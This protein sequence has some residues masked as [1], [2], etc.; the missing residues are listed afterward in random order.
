MPVFVFIAADLVAIAIMVFG[1]YFPR[2]RKREM[3]AP[4]LAINVGV[5]GV[6]YAMAT[7]DLSLGFGLG[8]FAVLSIIR[9]RSSEMDHAE[10]AYYFTAIALGLLGGFPSISESVSFTLMA[11]L[12]LVLAAGD[13]P[14]LFAR[15][16]QHMLVLDRAVPNEL[17]AKDLAEAMLGATVKRITIRKVD[18]VL[19]T[20]L[21]D[22]RYEVP[23]V[24][25][26]V[27]SPTESIP[28][29]AGTTSSFTNI[30]VTR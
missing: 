21:C 10:I 26:H 2:H 15:S 3:I 27:A 24:D 22:V 14:R 17:A 9:L 5:M 11:V 23:I 8:I 12:L 28:T 29:V 4:F 1:M 6:T 16:R 20:T 19:D 25:P 18:F 30:E 7:T 13:N